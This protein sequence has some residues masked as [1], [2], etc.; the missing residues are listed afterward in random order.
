MCLELQNPASGGPKILKNISKEQKI[1]TNI[2]REYMR[3]QRTIR[4][5]RITN[6]GVGILN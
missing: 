3:K 2:K 1:E 4:G 6:S 5:S